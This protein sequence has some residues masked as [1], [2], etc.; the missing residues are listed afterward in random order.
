MKIE[1]KEIDDFELVT[2]SDGLGVYVAWAVTKDGYELG[3]DELDA[4]KDSVDFQDYAFSW[5]Y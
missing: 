4:L 2:S 3:D 1:W 5:K